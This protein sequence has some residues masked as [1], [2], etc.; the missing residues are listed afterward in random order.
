MNLLI[1]HYYDQLGPIKPNH[2]R[3]LHELTPEPPVEDA[4]VAAPM[5]A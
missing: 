2:Y 1:Q 4:K 5:D 3:E